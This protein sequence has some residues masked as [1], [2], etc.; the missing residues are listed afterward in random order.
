MIYINPG[1]HLSNV[2]TSGTTMQLVGRNVCVMVLC[3]GVMLCCYGGMVL[4]CL[5]LLLLVVSAVGYMIFIFTIID[6]V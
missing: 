2:I 1:S 3:Y 6:L 5:L 4:W